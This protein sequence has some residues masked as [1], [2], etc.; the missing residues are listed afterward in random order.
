MFFYFVVFEPATTLSDQALFA[1]LR[2]YSLFDVCLQMGVCVCVIVGGELYML[3]QCCVGERSCRLC[4]DA[5]SMLECLAA[6]CPRRVQSWTPSAFT[7]LLG[8]ATSL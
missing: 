1:R 8:Y 6:V 7:I 5:L 3:E 4:S 2:F